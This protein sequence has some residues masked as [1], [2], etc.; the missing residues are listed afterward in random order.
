MTAVAP[1]SF[2]HRPCISQ[3]HA[4][5]TTGPTPCRGMLWRYSWHIPDQKWFTVLMP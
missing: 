1:D 4:G 3:G 2:E 5:R